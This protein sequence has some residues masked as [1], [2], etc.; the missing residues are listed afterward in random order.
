MP[1]E[2]VRT[3][4]PYDCLTFTAEP[5]TEPAEVFY[6]HEKPQ[7]KLQFANNTDKIVR[8]HIR[9]FL[10]FGPSGRYGRRGEDIAI[11][12]PPHSSGERIVGGF[13]LLYQDNCVIALKG[14]TES[15]KGAKNV[16]H[17]KKTNGLI[18]L[19]TFHPWE[20]RYYELNYKHPRRW[21]RYSF[22][23]VAIAGIATLV[24]IKSDIYVLLSW[25]W[26]II[27]NLS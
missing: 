7:F 1:A 14:V 21:Q 20:K 26:S 9:W 10:G 11:W 19:V 8:G 13:E 5:V 22:Y 3:V 6:T 27:V 18:A 2:T 24:N 23:A 16:I 25:I 4:G 12:L 17:V 15:S